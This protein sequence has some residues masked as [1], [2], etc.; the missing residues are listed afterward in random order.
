ML[1]KLA[2]VDPALSSPRMQASALR[3]QPRS[4][5]E[6]MHAAARELLQASS[7]PQPHGCRSV[8]ADD[9]SDRLVPSRAAL[10]PWQRVHS[11]SR[12]SCKLGSPAASRKG[13]GRAVRSARHDGDMRHEGDGGHAFDRR[14]RPHLYEWSSL[15][16]RPARCKASGGLGLEQHHERRQHAAEELLGVTPRTQYVRRTREQRAERAEA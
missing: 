13:R 5:E 1:L 12:A 14:L 15:L 8:H 16:L 2:A 3:G 4:A 7:S 6:S 10:R 9:C 11:Q